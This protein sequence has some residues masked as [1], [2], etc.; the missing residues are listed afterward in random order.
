MTQ[1]LRENKYATSLSIITIIFVGLTFSNL[2]GPIPSMT[3]QTIDGTT[4]NFADY[5]SIDHEL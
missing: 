4:F 2:P 5:N 1:V 3:A